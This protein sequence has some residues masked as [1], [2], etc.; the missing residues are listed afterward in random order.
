MNNIIMLMSAAERGSGQAALLTDN[1]LLTYA[2]CI[3][4]VIFAAICSS[5]VN[6]TFSKHSK[7][8]SR[9]GLQA[10]QVARMTDFRTWR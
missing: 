1:Y 2:L 5:R 3:A 7:T 4:A 10:H 8:F 9:R 6:S